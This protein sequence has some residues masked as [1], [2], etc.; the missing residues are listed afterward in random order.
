MARS[1]EAFRDHAGEYVSRNQGASF[2]RTPMGDDLKV[3][4][5]RASQITAPIQGLGRGAA[6]RLPAIRSRSIVQMGRSL[7]P[8]ELFVDDPRTVRA[9]D[10]TP[11]M[12]RMGGITRDDAGQEAEERFEMT[13]RQRRQQGTEVVDMTASHLRRRDIKNLGPDIR[14]MR[15]EGTS[16][17]GRNLSQVEDILKVSELEKV[18]DLP[19]VVSREVIFSEFSK[20]TAT[21]MERQA[22]ATFLATIHLLAL[23]NKITFML[24]GAGDLIVKQ[25]P[26]TPKA[27]SDL[28]NLTRFQ[29]KLSMPN[30]LETLENLRNELELRILPTLG[31]NVKGFFPVLRE[32]GVKGAFSTEISR[33][34]ETTN[35]PDLPKQL[36]FG[37]LS[38]TSV[39][40]DIDSFNLI[41]QEIPTLKNVT[42]GLAPVIAAAIALGIIIIAFGIRH[43]LAAWAESIPDSPPPG[44]TPEERMAWMKYQAENKSWLTPLGETLATIVMV[45][46][47][48][49]G[50]GFAVWLGTSLFS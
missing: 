37:D 38:K 18:F 24:K 6:A 10:P 20:L 3:V 34:L 29:K 5:T 40:R 31:V 49:V 26:L 41:A 44:L 17:R 14:E 35:R 43:V 12:L 39:Y 36:D 45:G 32:A 23:R 11:A 28:T 50:I 33:S 1:Y 9:I 30:F 48:A 21:E 8:A 15:R 2:D 13:A 25:F 16:L 42:L 19:G 46:G 27:V 22:R 47:V 7:R 4:Q